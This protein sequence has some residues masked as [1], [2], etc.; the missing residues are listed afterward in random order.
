M[1][2]AQIIS[3][4]VRQIGRK[5]GTKSG[6]VRL[7]RIPAQQRAEIA[8]KA[9]TARWRTAKAKAKAKKEEQRGGL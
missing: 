6:T 5:G 2:K 1:K 4:Y 8:R 3:E 7:E 9:A